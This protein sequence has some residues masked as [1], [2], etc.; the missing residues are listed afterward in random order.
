MWSPAGVAASRL[1]VDHVTSTKVDGGVERADCVTTS[2][3]VKPTVLLTGLSMSGSTMD[4]VDGS[5]PDDSRRKGCV[6]DVTQ[7]RRLSMVCTG[8]PEH[9]CA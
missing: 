8:Q 9:A 2:M 1:P 7:L 4:V 6:S 3:R 5:R